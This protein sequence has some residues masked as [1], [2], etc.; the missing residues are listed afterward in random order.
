MA[1]AKK[2]KV[3]KK[4]DEPETITK[5]RE[6]KVVWVDPPPVEKER[7]V[8]RLSMLADMTAEVLLEN[9]KM[10]VLKPDQTKAIAQQWRAAAKK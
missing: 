9:G 4:T 2:K 5:T 10:L 8:K 6:P 7:P 3:I 1:I